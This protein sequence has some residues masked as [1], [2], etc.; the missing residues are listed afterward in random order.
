LF[1]IVILNVLMLTQNKINAVLLLNLNVFT[2]FPSKFFDRK[3][4]PNLIQTDKFNTT[5]SNEISS[6]LFH[7]S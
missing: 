7:L 1:F 3:I 5:L 2:Y 6:I 4:V